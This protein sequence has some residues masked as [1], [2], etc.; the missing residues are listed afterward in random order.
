MEDVVDKADKGATAFRDQSVYRL[1][2]IKESVPGRQRYL[3][4]KPR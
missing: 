2:G 1:G 3:R 4:R